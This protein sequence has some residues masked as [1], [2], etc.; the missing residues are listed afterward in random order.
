M[1]LD[2]AG[3]GSLVGPLV[4]GG[5]LVPESRLL[6]LAGLGAKDSK[7]LSAS[8]RVMVYRRLASVGR[9]V[10]VSLSPRTIDRYVADGRLNRLEAEAMAS[11]IHEAGPSCAYVDAC[12][13]VAERFGTLVSRLS[14]CPTVVI[15]RHRADRDLPVVGAAS[16][17]AKVRRDRALERLR[18]TLGPELGSGYPSDER[19]VK[20]VRGTL[21]AAGPLPPW[22]RRSWETTARLMRERS[23]RALESF[24]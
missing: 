4:V 23:A 21:A 22:L 16:I 20:F 2:E 3:R 18:A 12:D 17:V 14:R 24:A 19:T 1:G 7:L 11:L 15:A 13:P 9:A 5:F 10:S 8:E 6:D